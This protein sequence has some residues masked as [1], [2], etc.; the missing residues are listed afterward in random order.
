[1]AYRIRSTGGIVQRKLQLQKYLENYSLDSLTEKYAIKCTRHKKYPNLILFKYNQIDSPFNEQIVRESRGIIL[2]EADNWRV[3]CHTFNKFF[4][5]GEKSAAKID[6]ASGVVQEKLDGSLCQLYYYDGV[7]HVA[8]SGVPDGSGCVRFSNQTFTELFWETWNK[9]GYNINGM[10]AEPYCFAFELTSPKNR[11]V[12]QYLDSNLTLIGMRHLQTGVEVCLPQSWGLK[13]PR[14]YSLNSFDEIQATFPA[15]NPLDSEGYVVVDRDFN[16]VKVK[17]PAYVALHHMKGG[18]N[19]KSVVNI[20]RKNESLEFLNAFPEYKEDVARISRN[21]ANLLSELDNVW[22]LVKET[23]DQKEFALRI[24]DHPC[25]SGFFMLRSKR[26][27][28]FRQW[29]SQL[30]DEKALELIG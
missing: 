17:N 1:M 27:L 28:S 21:Y 29:F 15:L 25:S 14:Q 8:T 13:T 11:V 20:V 3:V 9:L 12:V 10:G 30:T 23:V 5:Y 2:D 4:N 7:W 16:R 22:S 18:I 19:L 26:V 24:K 6:W